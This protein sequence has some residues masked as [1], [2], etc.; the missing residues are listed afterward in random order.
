[1]I[2]LDPVEARVIGSLAEKQLTTPQQYPLTLNALL[3][4]CNQSSNR[5]PVVEYDDT[6][7]EVALSSLKEAGLLRFV[8][9]SHG[10]SVTRYRQVIDERFALDARGLS[11]MAVLLLRGAQTVGEVRARTERMADFDDL[12]AVEAELARLGDGPDPLV[13]RLPRHHGQKEERWA[14]LLTGEPIWP[15][16]A[17]GLSDQPAQARPSPVRDEVASMRAE[18]D[19][20]GERLAAVEAA[21]EEIRGAEGP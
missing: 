20:L 6:I 11:V 17:S 8:Y 19:A 9:P 2:E 10:R 21:L 12:G 1:M 3:L 7:V 4:A 16:A 15:T 18:I 14:Q 13:R 5:D